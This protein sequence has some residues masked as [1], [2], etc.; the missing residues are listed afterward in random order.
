MRRLVIL[1]AGAA[2]ALGLA[3]PGMAAATGETTSSPES[4]TICLA[5][6]A[7]GGREAEDAGEAGAGLS[8]TVSGDGSSTVFPIMEAVAE[9][10]QRENPGVRV[11]IGISGTGGGFKKFCAGETDLSNASRPI[12]PTE[13]EACRAAGVEYVEF[14]IAFD[15]LSVM[16]NPDNDFAACIEIAELRR[17][18]EPGAQGSH[19]TV[20]S[21]WC[22]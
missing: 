16:V 1:T 17:L 12:K 4:T 10:F 20:W 14:P 6:A 11:T 15:G 7:C 21:W 8:G 3:I 19:S 18:W 5:A 2:L 9:E 13:V 22:R